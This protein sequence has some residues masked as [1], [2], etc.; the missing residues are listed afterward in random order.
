MC[1]N[2]SIFRIILENINQMWKEA[3]GGQDAVLVSVIKAELFLNFNLLA[4]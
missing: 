3:K 4:M 1:L 2:A